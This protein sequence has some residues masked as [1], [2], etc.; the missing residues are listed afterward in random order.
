MSIVFI[1][2][3]IVILLPFVIALFVSKEYSVEAGIVI[4]KPKHEVF[5]Y[6]KIVENQ[7]A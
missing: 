7:E 1:I 5:D 2:I 3:V 4:N 6:L